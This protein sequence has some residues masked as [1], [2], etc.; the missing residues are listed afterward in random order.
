[1]TSNT[2]LKSRARAYAAERGISYTQARREILDGAQSLSDRAESASRSV[3]V[4][5][6]QQA[7]LSS[8][9]MPYPFHV[10]QSGLV[11]RQDYWRGDPLLLIGFAADAEDRSID[12][13]AV[14]FAADPAQVQGMHPVFESAD[15]S[16]ATWPGPVEST[17]VRTVADDDPFMVQAHVVSG[18]GED[19]VTVGV[20]HLMRF[21]S[22]GDYEGDPAQGVVSG[23]A[24]MRLVRQVAL[25]DD[26]GQDL[27]LL[28]GL[29]EQCGGLPDPDEIDRAGFTV[30]VTPG[31]V[32]SWAAGRGQGG[33][34]EQ[35]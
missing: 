21:L 4:I 25:V 35:Q 2:N 34:G 20:G 12:V 22:A 16:W 11:D 14:D 8:G 6:V 28:D 5:T 3:R 31:D 23:A 13:R 7:T 18:D 19:R 26:A 27:G 30:S 24:A 32:R 33:A 9:K 17:T 10:T 1:M 29:L 15:G